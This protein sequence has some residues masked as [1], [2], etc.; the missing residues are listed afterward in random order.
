MFPGPL[1]AREIP[2]VFDIGLFVCTAAL[3]LAALIFGGAANIGA[4]GDIV[5][6][7]TAIPCLLIAFRRTIATRTI[8]STPVVLSACLLAL[9]L[10]QLIPLP[11]TVWTKLPGSALVVDA[12]AALGA[13]PGW[14]PLSV[15]PTLTWLSFVSMLPPVAMFLAVVHLGY[16]ARQRLGVIIVFAGIGVA[17]VGMLQVLGGSDSSLYL[18]AD[19]PRGDAVGFFANRNHFAALMYSL[20]VLTSAWSVLLRNGGA[21]NAVA[22][23]DQRVMFGVALA[24]AMLIFFAAVMVTRSRSGFL[25]GSA[26]ALAAVVLVANQYAQDRAARL[27]IGAGIVVA[28]VVGLQFALPKVI[29]RFGDDP[30][31]DAR[32]A[33][34]ATT[35]Q[36]VRAF[37]PTGAGFG[38]F[39]P[40]YAHFERLQDILPDRYVNHA[41]NEWLQLI[42]ETGLLGMLVIAGAGFAL[43]TRVGR[44]WS[45][46]DR[47]ASPLDVTMA[48]AAAVVLVLVSLH[49]FVEFPMRTAAMAVT[50]AF[51]AG[52]L[53]APVGSGQDADSAGPTLHVGRE[54]PAASDRRQNASTGSRLTGRPPPR[55]LAEIDWPTT[56]SADTANVPTEAPP[57][58]GGEGESD[59]PTKL[60]PDEEA[61]PEEWRS[62]PRK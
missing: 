18:F 4:A 2:E 9:P 35:W 45:N 25:L 55:H 30:M 22:S 40:V 42:L 5:V 52:L 38:T 7:L 21:S 8:V 23:Q 54:H 26:A 1:V 59:K 36:A 58:S 50:L 34:A 61:W 31:D 46:P 60:E 11:S 37:F 14:R 19:S 44:I 6:Q 49:S 16:T 57:Q 27:A 20:L 24:G 10:I 41:H 28:I 43:F 62:K 56:T 32:W 33:I 29:A 47:L 3:L 51:C 17:L 13:S 39:V 48:R 15:A 53:F 12:Y